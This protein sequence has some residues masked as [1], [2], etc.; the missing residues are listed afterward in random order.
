MFNDVSVFLAVRT[1]LIF[2]YL[3]T[4]YTLCWHI[5]PNYEM[6]PL[7]MYI[8]RLIWFLFLYFI[9]LS[10]HSIVLV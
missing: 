3:F 7:I 4:I 6:F 10:L 8:R 5:H 2:F 9:G 1:V